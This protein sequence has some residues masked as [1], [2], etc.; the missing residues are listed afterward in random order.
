MAK[1]GTN[2]EKHCVLT[3][4]LVGRIISKRTKEK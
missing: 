3:Y 2:Y 4:A 1:A